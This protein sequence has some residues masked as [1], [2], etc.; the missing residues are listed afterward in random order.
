MATKSVTKMIIKLDRHKNN[1]FLFPDMP[2]V[3]TSLTPETKEN[4]F[5]QMIRGS[6][7]LGRVERRFSGIKMGQIWKK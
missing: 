3:L 5:L 4:G 7:K 2:S 6:H 1:G